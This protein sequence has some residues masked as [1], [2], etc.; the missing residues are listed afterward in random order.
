MMQQN[1]RRTTAASTANPLKNKSKNPLA[2]ANTVRDI[3]APAPGLFESY[4][5]ALV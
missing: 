3:K 1:F 4:E 5:L 2:M